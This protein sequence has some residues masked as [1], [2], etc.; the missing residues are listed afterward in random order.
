MSLT[1]YRAAPP[2]VKARINQPVRASYSCNKASFEGVK[3]LYFL[4]SEKS[5]N[6]R[7]SMA[8][9][10]AAGDGPRYSAD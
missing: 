8:L 6:P 4:P 9:A 10:I 5:E 2:R 1:S 3:L 7:F